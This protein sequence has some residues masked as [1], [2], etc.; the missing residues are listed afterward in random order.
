M[1]AARLL[2]LLSGD[3]PDGT[4]IAEDDFGGGTL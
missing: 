4:S 2:S 1:G 3:T